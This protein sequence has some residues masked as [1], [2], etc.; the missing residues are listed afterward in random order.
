MIYRIAFLLTTILSW[1]SVHSQ[2]TPNLSKKDLGIFDTDLLPPSFHKERRQKLRELMPD[3]SV[4]IFLMTSMLT[5]P[6]NRFSSWG[7]NYSLFIYLYHFFNLSK[8]NN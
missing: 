1:F 2:E 3:S 8:K 4:A 6:D 5:I 7:K